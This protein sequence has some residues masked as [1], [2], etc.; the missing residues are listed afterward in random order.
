METH[1]FK[2]TI[3][4]KGLNLIWH[5]HKIPGTPQQIVLVGHKFAVLHKQKDF[6]VS[7]CPK[8]IWVM[9]NCLS[10]PSRAAFDSSKLARDKYLSQK[11]G[12]IVAIIRQIEMAL[13]LHWVRIKQIQQ[14]IHTPKRDI[15]CLSC[16]NEA[17]IVLICC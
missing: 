10:T 16:K 12:Q 9:A 6:L 13:F 1:L 17:D 2:G 15:N 4:P 5:R 7:V 11:T 3:L 14:L 8:V